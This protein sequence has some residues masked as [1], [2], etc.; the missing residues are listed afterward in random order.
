VPDDAG[1]GFD[2]YGSV[3][4]SLE[5]LGA[6]A[7]GPFQT[8]WPSCPSE[9]ETGYRRGCVVLASPKAAPV[10]ADLPQLRGSPDAAG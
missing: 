5:Y 6:E 8:L 2:V 3:E 10:L 4:L 1:Y 7:I 9:E